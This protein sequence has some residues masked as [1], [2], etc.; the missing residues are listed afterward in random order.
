VATAQEEEEEDGHD[1]WRI[2]NK[3]YRD[4]YQV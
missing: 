2:M 1:F 3:E 4:D